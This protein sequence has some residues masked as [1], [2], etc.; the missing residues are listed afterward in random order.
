MYVY[1]S[2]VPGNSTVYILCVFIV[3]FVA[4]VDGTM[5]CSEPRAIILALSAFLQ[6]VRM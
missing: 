2:P 1:F 4:V 6:C 3:W 5:F